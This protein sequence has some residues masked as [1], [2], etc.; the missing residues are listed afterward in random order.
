[1]QLG[2]GHVLFLFE[3]ATRQRV[4]Y[5]KADIQHWKLQ[6]KK[7]HGNL[8]LWTGLVHKRPLTIASINTDSSSTKYIKQKKKKKVRGSKEIQRACNL[9]CCPSSSVTNENKCYSI[10]SMCRVPDALRDTLYGCVPHLF[11]YP[12]KSTSKYYQHFSS[13]K[14]LKLQNIKKRV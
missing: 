5:I 6:E 8:S 2:S 11:L 7:D 12:L 14:T 13:A 1:M 4:R 9:Y 10:P 3:S